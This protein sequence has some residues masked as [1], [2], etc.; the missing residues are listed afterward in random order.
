MPSK[1]RKISLR[2]TDQSPK[3]QSFLLSSSHIRHF[4]AAAEG[5]GLS[6]FEEIFFCDGL[7]IDDVEAA[8]K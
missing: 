5:K 4:T 6:S 8:G 1:Q 7:D 2:P 3:R